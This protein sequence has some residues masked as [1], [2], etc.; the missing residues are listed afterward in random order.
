[1]GAL[2]LDVI[3]VGIVLKLLHNPHAAQHFKWGWCLAV[4]GAVMWKLKGSTIGGIICG[5]RCRPYRWS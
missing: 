4:Y 5:L 2:L 3:L 1:M